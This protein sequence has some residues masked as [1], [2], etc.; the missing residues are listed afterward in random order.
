MAFRKKL[1]KFG[2]NLACKYL[3][4]NGFEIIERNYQCRYGEIDIIAEKEN[5]IYFFEVKSRRIYSFGEPEESITSD[6]V[7]KIVLSAKYYLNNKKLYN[8]SC[9]FD[10][11]AIN[12][13]SNNIQI[14]HLEDITSF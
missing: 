12:I 13:Y 2:E 7:N 5:T 3:K 11:I 8:L 10:A 6:K 9:Q 1:G 4:N 14:K